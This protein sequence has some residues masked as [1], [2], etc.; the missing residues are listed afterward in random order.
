MSVDDPMRNTAEAERRPG[1]AYESEF[2]W[3]QTGAGA[4]VY[5]RHSHCRIPH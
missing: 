5:F 3:Q 1:P 2:L 4:G